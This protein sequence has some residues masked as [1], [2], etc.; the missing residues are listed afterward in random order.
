MVKRKMTEAVTSADPK[1]KRW[2][3]TFAAARMAYQTGEF[4]QAESLLARAFELAK[5][6]PE[7]SFAVPA[8][9]IG[10]AAVW[11]AE[12]R[13][14]EAEKRLQK[15][16]SRLESFGDSTH[17]ELAAVAMRFHAQALA[18][19]GDVRGAEKELLKSAEILTQLGDDACVQLAYTLCDLCGLYLTQGRFPEA[20]QRVTRAMHIL[21]NVFGTE[22][23]EYVRADMIYA[24]CLPME[25]D[26]RMESVKDGIGKMEYMYG[27]K[28]PN[29][30][31]ALDRYF[32]VLEERG[33][34]VRLQEAQKRFT[35][36]APTKK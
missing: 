8:S 20:E 17:R 34:T 32:K 1:T 18:E 24:V 26:S 19:T 11:L 7:H 21:G 36:A 33:D 13:S 9:E 28:H 12:R 4:R 25:A 35:V 10:M 2:R 23:P 3:S 5:E 16:V 15:C 6:L 22:D 14:K 30:H 31:R 27:G 29:I